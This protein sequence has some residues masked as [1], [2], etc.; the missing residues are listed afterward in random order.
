MSLLQRA[1]T[2]FADIRREEVPTALLM[3]AYS[4][5]AMTSY[6]I[7]QP[8]TRS[9]LIASLGAVNV[10]WVIFGSGLFIGVLMLGYTRLVS[11]LPRRWALPITQAGMAGMMFVFWALFRTGAEWVSVAFYVWGLLLGVLLISQFWTLANG[12]YDPRQA[13]RLFGLIGGGVALGGMTGAGVTAAIIERV[14]TSALLIGSGVTLIACLVIV[15]LIL[16]RETRAAEVGA[17]VDEER[18]VSVGR[19]LALLRG[20]RQIQLISVVIGFG[21]IGAA[22]IDQQLNMAAEVFRGVG[23]ENSIGAFL[24]QVRFYL[25]LA[26]FVIQV[27]ITPRIHRYLGIGFALLILPT[28]LGIT[29]ALIVLYKVLWAPAFASVMDRSFRYTV[30]KTTREVLFLPLPSQLRQ[31]V[32]PFVDVTVDRVSRGVGALLMLVLIQPWGL[33]LEWYQLSFVSA[34]LAIIWYFMAFRAKR[35]YLASF[36]R[37]IEQRVV[38]PEEVRLSGSELST[39]ESLVQELAHPDPARVVY[40]IDVLESLDKRNLVTPLLLYHEAPIVR[41]RALAALGAARPD[42]A[43]RWAPH[44]RR[45]LGDA[46]AG[47]RAAAIAALCVISDE[48]AATLARP[49]LSDPD[50]RIRV[51]AAAALA[52]SRAGE[53]AEAAEATLVDIISDT[54]GDARDA[55]RDVAS[56]IR[57]TTDPRFRRLL[58]PLLYDPAPEVADEAMESVRAAGAGDFVFVP[59]L[60]ALLR[61]RRLKGQARSVL[62]S[63][64][65]PV[66]DALAHFMREEQ[67]DIWVRRHIPAT[68]ALI[69]SQKSVNALAGALE[70]P[71]G[72]LRY[73]VV[74][75]LER[76]RRDADGLTFPREMIE[77]LTLSEARQYFNYLSLRFNVFGRK[78]LPPDSLL[79]RALDQKLER[80]L[81]RVFRLLALIYPWKD[82]GAARWTLRHGDPRSRANALEYLDNILTGQL[83]KQILPLLED[84]P[85]E[86]K[87][88]RANVLLRTRL[89]D[90]E[91][92]LLQLINDDDQIVAAAAID[93]VRQQKMWTLGDDIEHVLAHRDAR[94][95]YVFEAASWALAERRMP[96]ERRRELW[97]EPLPAAELAGRIRHLPLFASLTVDEL[98]RITGAARQVRHE[99]GSV[100]LQ[101]GAAPESIHLLLDGSVVASSRD[102][103]PRRIEAPAALGFTEALAGT[104]MR[105]TL[106]TAD[107]AVTLVLTMEELRTLLSENTDL[108]IGLFTTLANRTGAADTPVHPTGAAVELEA[109]AD[110]GLAPV[111]KVLALQRVPAFSRVSAEEMRFLADIARIVTMQPGSVLFTESAPPAVWL[112]LSGEVA[113][114][115]SAGGAPLTARGG[116]V[117]GSVSTMA[118]H[119]LERSAGVV[120]GGLALRLDREDLFAVTAERPELLRQ[121]FAGF[122]KNEAFVA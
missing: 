122:F 19:A 105:E 44:I 58:I 101:E 118:G 80:T 32:K 121:L 86:E 100:L 23:Q 66:I 30:D 106:R 107:V 27:W 8:L 69:P 79:S 120:R 97:H 43:Q 65:E 39:V 87:V 95:W 82:I 71:D 77:R 98:F 54:S 42:I 47:V 53:D 74:A 21:S 72:F 111:E 62:V 112:L 29:A 55:R 114:E 104:G 99:P 4:F 67:E 17:A 33:A 45:M 78:T 52:D 116:D 6:N 35:E 10:P 41:T 75:A 109:L 1:L 28:N 24:A 63:Y 38:K 94:D 68:L 22:L 46:D 37:S 89:R 110:Q 83:R 90:T 70:E 12:I 108:V 61:H 36:R 25:S 113:L 60:I 50:P 73:K 9:K 85:I 3:F 57:Q 92:T 18:G 91:E 20:S 26:A 51:T 5:L 31:E 93:V 48:D 103:I 49:M 14:G 76:L 13:K 59:T 11:A 115:S 84:M 117:I 102:G 56:A 15:S 64:G 34:G 2:P 96:A 16:G 81:D 88:R 40:A 119:R 7:I